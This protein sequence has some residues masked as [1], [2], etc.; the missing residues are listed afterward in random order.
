LLH[1][2][3]AEANLYVR[4]RRIIAEPGSKVLA[5]DTTSGPGD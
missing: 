2:A 5:F 4:A 1:L 3:D